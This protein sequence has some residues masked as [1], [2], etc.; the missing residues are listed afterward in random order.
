V[1]LLNA[2]LAADRLFCVSKM[3]DCRTRHLLALERK[4]REVFD[5]SRVKKRTGF[6]TRRSQDA[7]AGSHGRTR[8]LMMG[9]GRFRAVDSNVKKSTRRNRNATADHCGSRMAAL[10]RPARGV[11]RGTA[12]RHSLPS[13]TIAGMRKAIEYEAIESDAP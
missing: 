10:R 4:I 12:V 6:L 13:S 2:L 11:D 7:C 9:Q 5:S 8:S 3:S 1:R